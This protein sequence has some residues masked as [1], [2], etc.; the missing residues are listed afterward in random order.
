MNESEK[1]P[2][3]HSLVEASTISWVLSLETPPGSHGKHARKSSLWLQ[4][5]KGKSNHWEMG[6]PEPS[7][8]KKPTLQG[9][10]EP[11]PC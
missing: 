10:S 6:H 3:S 8:Q 4:R 11:Y 5:E 9:F 1:P 2:E 7:R